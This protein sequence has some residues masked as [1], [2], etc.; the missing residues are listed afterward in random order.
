[1][2]QPRPEYRF[3]IPAGY[4][5]EVAEGKKYVSLTERCT[6]GIS[7][8]SRFCNCK[9][10]ERDEAWNLIL[11]EQREILTDVWLEQLRQ[12]LRLKN[13][14]RAFRSKPNS[15]TWNYGA[16]YFKEKFERELNVQHA[17]E[18]KPWL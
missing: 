8:Q 9:S 17:K 16:T 5:T 10:L 18:I 7:L 11:K 14:L 13:V 6:Y 2:S 4:G 12:L 3:L 1:V 15:H